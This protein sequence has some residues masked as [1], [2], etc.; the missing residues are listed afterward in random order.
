MIDVDVLGGEDSVEAF[1]REC[2]FA[3][4]KIRYMRFNA[5]MWAK[6]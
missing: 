1:E 4:E 6:Q 5:S 2:S 3:V